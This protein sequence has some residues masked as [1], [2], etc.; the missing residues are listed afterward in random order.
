[1][2]SSEFPWHQFWLSDLL[3]DFCISSLFALLYSLQSSSSVLFQFSIVKTE[4]KINDLTKTL[5]QYLELI[6]LHSIRVQSFSSY[7]QL[8]MF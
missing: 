8:N 4:K 3:F 6:S 1:M 2:V 5:Q 7:R